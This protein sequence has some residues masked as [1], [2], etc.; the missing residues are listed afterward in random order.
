MS[1]S[2][3]ERF[4]ELF[5]KESKR[6]LAAMN[7]ALLKAEKF[8]E[9]DEFIRQFAQATHTLKSIADAQQYHQMTRLCHAIEDLLDAIKS[10]RITIDKCVDLLFACCDVLASS[11]K[12]LEAGEEE[13]S[14]EELISKIK[15]VIASPDQSPGT[16]DSS[17]QSPPDQPASTAGTLPRNDDEDGADIDASSLSASEG[18]EAIS[19]RNVIE[20][21]KSVDVKVEKL[22]ALMRLAEELLVNKMKFEGLTRKVSLDEHNEAVETLGR[23]VDELQYHVVQ[24]RMVPIGYVFDRFPRMVRDIAK[25]QKK[26]VEI[27]MSGSDIELDR[28]VIDEIGE[29][30]VHL[31]RN[32]IDHGLETTDER[33]KKGK[34]SRGIIKV[35]AAR[36]KEFAVIEVEDDGSGLD[37][38]EIKKTARQRGI[39][40]ENVTDKEIMDTIFSGVSTTKQVTEVSGRG[41]GL[42]IVKKK[43]ESLSGFVR[44]E[45]GR[46]T[47]TRFVIEIP[48]TMAIIKAMFVRVGPHLYAIPI[49]SIDRVVKVEQDDIKGMLNYEAIVL[50]ESDIPITRLDV[51]FGM[52]WSDVKNK[53]L[54]IV[55][56][57]KEKTGLLVDELVMTQEIVI[58]PLN[59]A[60]KESKYCSGTA[61]IGSGDAV[62]VLDTA[63][64]ILSQREAVQS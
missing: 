32:A 56:K 3:Q 4:K 36:A 25:K 10:K 2:E 51:L 57:D 22:D 34:Q 41:L 45:P 6:H 60:V 30:L 40:G 64:L 27:E 43:I 21:I 37:M 59:P 35:S 15:L 28:S 23:L 11:V 9:H 26:E 16:G 18:F 33:K 55:T 7:T 14:A 1:Q 50:E 48:L 31:L 62:L 58:K 17:S 29:S 61:I 49:S 46:Q 19:A 44:V 63:N 12:R 24:A 53:V 13:L 42:N 47:G 52:A 39:L 8:S 5:L 54:V 38:D 20:K